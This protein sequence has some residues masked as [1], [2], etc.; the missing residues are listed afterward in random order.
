MPQLAVAAVFA[1]GAGTAATAAGFAAY[2]GI[3]A[4]VG[5]A[6]GSMVGGRM[7]GP[8]GAKAAMADLRTPKL[9]MG[10][11]KH[12]VYG[13][14]R[15]ALSPKWQSEWRATANESGGKGGGGSEFYTYSCDVL[16]WIS[17]IAG[18]P[19][20][21]RVQG[22]R[23]LWWN[24]ELVWSQHPDSAAETLE[25]GANADKWSA[26]TFFDGSDDQLPWPVYEA[27]LGAT[28][29]DA[30]RRIACLAF[31]NIQTGTWSN[32][33]LL[34]VEV[35]TEG[36]EETIETVDWVAYRFHSPVDSGM[37]TS[38]VNGGVIAEW[39]P[40]VNGN[41]GAALAQAAGMKLLESCAEWA[42]VSFPDPDAT[43]TPPSVVGATST[44]TGFVEL[45]GHYCD[46][47]DNPTS[48]YWIMQAQAGAVSTI[49]T[50]EV[51]PVDLADIVSAECLRSGLTA[52]D[53]DVTALVGV[54]VHGFMA[55]GS[56]RE[57]IE[58]L[59][60]IFHF[61]A[62][63][64]D[65]LYFKLLDAASIATIP[66]ADTGVGVD[67]PGEPFT[68][69]ERGNDIEVPSE[70]TVVSP[71][72]SADYDP[73]AETYDRLQTAG[74]R[75][76]QVNSL[77][78][79]TPAER[80][81]RAIT[82]ALDAR[83][84]MHTARVTLDDTYA[85]LEPGDVIT[86]TDE[87]GNTY[88]CRISRESYSQGVHDCEIRLFDRS[89]L[90]ET[91]T[92][93]DTYTPVVNIAIPGD[94]FLFLLDMPILRDADDGYG[95]YIA[96]QLTGAS[97]GAAYRSSDGTTFTSVAA[98]TNTAR[99][100]TTDTELGD[101]AGGN[102]WDTGNV[103]RATFNGTLSSASR[104]SVLDSGANAFAVVK[105]DGTVEIIQPRTVTLVSSADGE[106]TYD[107]SEML[108]GRRGTEHAA[109]GHAS[110]EAIVKLDASLLNRYED[111]AS[112]T[113]ALRYFKGV[114][115]G[116][117][118]SGVV[119]V[120]FTNTQV[121]LKPFAPVNLRANRD[122]PDAIVLTW[123]RR[124]RMSGEFL[125]GIEI[126]LGESS[127]SYDVLIYDD[128]DALVSTTTVA[129]AT[130]S[131]DITSDDHVD[132]TATVYQRSAAVGRGYPVSITL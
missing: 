103:L 120:E 25:E 82:F 3:A 47:P 86:P 43:T 6:V 18:L 98:A 74:R 15:V 95:H 127:E 5:W 22:I 23:R 48:G 80:K 63:C 131:I 130:H 33:P 12:R 75:K 64:S 59:M 109:T 40:V 55:Q 128:T 113:G 28:N 4:S 54:E 57:A 129:S 118:V 84:A 9:T 14:A 16:Y 114:T 71:N 35:Y 50:V 65:K 124:T 45:A 46:Q 76:A 19:E 96:I 106:Y 72:I 60:G 36:T 56:A 49:T 89:V 91:G 78:V 69:L 102:A 112:D 117:Q 62:V 108:R 53:I 87:D 41:K 66:F 81:G 24:G 68:G 115:A 79:M 99:V 32:L 34:E 2:A 107:L 8:D 100:G 52:N 1:W 126:P 27:A 110:G 88:V 83:T 123:D 11:K 119:A 61:Y 111:G 58:D 51:H 10:S 73:G 13:T 7:F 17:D 77:V 67:Q 85:K 70:M 20:N 104:D 30:H 97:A 29:A 122:D 31:E 92:T 44:L 105:A 132:Y 42:F 121:G 37:S 93:S 116:R 125:D 101:W 90:T 26:M 21:L 38:S 39:V 94:T